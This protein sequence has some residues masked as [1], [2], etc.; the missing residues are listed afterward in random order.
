M[1]PLIKAYCRD[2]RD[3]YDEAEALVAEFKKLSGMTAMSKKREHELEARRNDIRNKLEWIKGRFERWKDEL[4]EM[5]ITVCS[6]RLGRVDIPVFCETIMSSVAF[7]VSPDTDEEDM[8]WHQLGE[9]HNKA[10]PYFTE[11]L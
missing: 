3:S 10:K 9:D 6:A 1:L 8:E 11:V 7:C 4:G 5:F 2:I